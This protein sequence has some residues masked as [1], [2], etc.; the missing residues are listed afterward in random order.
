[1]P[2]SDVVFVECQL[3]RSGFSS[4][5][6]FRLETTT[7]GEEFIGTAPVQYCRTKAKKL[8]SPDEPEERKPIKGLVEARVIRKEPDSSV[9]LYFPDGS[10]AQVSEK[11]LSEQ[12]SGKAPDVS[13]KS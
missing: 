5:R 2:E 1:M 13:L 4:E 12:Q 8:L 3:S 10:V 7:P 9:W 6:V 11:L